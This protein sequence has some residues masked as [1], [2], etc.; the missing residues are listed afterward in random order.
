MAIRLASPLASRIR[1]VLQDFLPAELDLIDTEES[2]TTPDVPDANYHLWDRPVV[3]DYP[4]VTVQVLSSRPATPMSIHSDGFGRFADV[5]HEAE[6]KVHVQVRDA[7]NK[8]EEIQ[9]LAVRYA[10]GIVRVLAMMK[11]GLQTSADATRFVERVTWESPVRYGLEGDQESGLVR[12][13]TI[14][15]NVRTRES[16]G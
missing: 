6:V 11:D 8:A 10:A 12:T 5:L 9:G 14:P 1:Q 4:A 2:S 15:L 3:E 7:V 16:R 13:A